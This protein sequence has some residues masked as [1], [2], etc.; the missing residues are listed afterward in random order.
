MTVLSLGYDICDW[1]TEYLPL[2]GDPSRP[3]ELTDEQAQFVVRLLEVDARGRFVHRHGLLMEPKGWGKSP[4]D[5]ALADAFFA[6]PVVFDGFGADGRPIGRPWGTGGSKRP[7]VQIAAV[8]QDQAASNVFVLAWEM[9]AVNDGRAAT[10]LGIDAGKTRLY[11]KDQPGAKLESVSSS[12]GSRSGQRVTF[13]V[14][15]ETDLWTPQSGGEK[16]A[17]T[18]RANIAKT[19]GLSMESANA[20]ELGARSV[21][22][23]TYRAREDGQFDI[24]VYANRPSIEPAPSMD[25]EQL[26]ALLKEVYGD[27]DWLDLERILADVRDPAIPW[28]ESSRLF[29]NT[30]ATGLEAFIDPARWVELVSQTRS[31][32]RGAAGFTGSD[33]GAALVF[34][35]EDGLITLLGAWSRPPGEPSWKVNRGEVHRA[36]EL[37]F[38]D[39]EVERFYVNPRQW[40]SEMEDW[41]EQYG[42]DDPKKPIVIKVPTDSPRRFGVAVDRF[43]IAVQEGQLH[44]VP[45]DELDHHLANCRL[46]IAR[47]GH[48]LESADPGRPIAAAVAAALAFEARAD[49]P[50][51]EEIDPPRFIPLDDP[52]DDERGWRPVVG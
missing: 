50:H 3:F 45:D 16:L 7:W 44:H 27:S 15:D 10:A 17:R 9:L 29:F 12:R 30:P 2:P 42:S 14:L 20:F 49:I 21:A 6:G 41:S 5:A 48:L 34:A 8:S 4:L 36:V 13:A 52:M 1:I 11:L 39:Y 23:Q 24:L 51:E 32:A 40:Q 31:K 43:R 25:N 18:I 37:M 46:V 22:E 38:D 19:G 28:G 26:L 33:N 35:D 47:G